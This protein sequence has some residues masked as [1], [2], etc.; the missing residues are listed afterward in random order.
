MSIGT[1]SCTE[2]RE[3]RYGCRLRYLLR[4][5]ILNTS[6]RLCNGCRHT[7]SCLIGSGGSLRTAVRDIRGKIHHDA[8]L[9][10][11]LASGDMQLA[12]Q[13]RVTP[14]I[15]TRTRSRRSWL[16]SCQKVPLRVICADEGSGWLW[17]IKRLQTP[18]KFLV[19][20]KVQ[21][22][23]RS[24]VIYLAI[25]GM[26]RSFRW[27]CVATVVRFLLHF[28]DVFV[29]TRQSMILGFWGSCGFRT[30]LNS[31]H[32]KVWETRSRDMNCSVYL[33][34]LFRLFGL[35]SSRRGILSHR[36]N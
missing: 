27:D 1:A 25:E 18:A 33:V 22:G 20:R 28:G 29:E 4:S 34:R 11:S 3:W 32:A 6:L 15:L 17:A 16:A 2:N 5:G 35:G 10:L 8:L 30:V 24:T 14:M 21:I 13:V 7:G 36:F 19:G 31:R 23:C 26:R 12:L 9:V